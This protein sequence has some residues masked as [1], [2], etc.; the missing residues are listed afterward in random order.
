MIPTQGCYQPSKGYRYYIFIL[1]FLLY[2]YKMILLIEL[3]ITAFI[4]A[5][6]AVTQ[7]VVHPG[8]RD[9]SYAICVIFQNLLGASLG[10]IIIGSISDKYDIIT[11][12]SVLPVFLIIAAAFFYAGSFFYERNL[13]KVEK[14]ELQFEN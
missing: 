2:L 10:P 12:L 1:L 11:A 7:D 8:L 6:A 5:A 3:S 13:N 14:I 9:V 4:P